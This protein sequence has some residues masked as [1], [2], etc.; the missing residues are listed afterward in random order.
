MLETIRKH[1]LTWL[2]APLTRHPEVNL[3]DLNVLKNRMD[4]L[5]RMIM[6]Q[7]QR[8]DEGTGLVS[9]TSDRDIAALPD[10]HL[11]AQ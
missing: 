5:E 1:L 9:P 10:A 6:T 2:N 11:G 4:T 7:I 8:P 3:H